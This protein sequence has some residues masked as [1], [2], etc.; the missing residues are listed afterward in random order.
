MACSKGALQKTAW[1]QQGTK[2]G[3]GTI[4]VDGKVNPR[5]FDGKS[6]GPADRIVSLFDEMSMSS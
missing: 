3:M 6:F 1:R 5:R 2:R 4:Q